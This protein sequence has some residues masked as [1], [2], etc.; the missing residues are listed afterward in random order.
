[1]ASAPHSRCSPYSARARQT[2]ATALAFTLLT[3]G[4][5]TPPPT[6]TASPTP[7]PLPCEAAPST[8]DDPGIEFSATLTS[9]AQRITVEYRV[10]NHN[11][12]PVH[13]PVFMPDVKG[14]PTR[15]SYNTIPRSDG[16]VEIS[17]RSIGFDDCPMLLYQAP[18][19]PLFLPLGPEST[20]A[21]TFIVAMPLRTRHPFPVEPGDI[22]PMPDHPETVVFCL[23]IMRSLE[24]RAITTTMEGETVYAASAVTD[25][26]FE[27]TDPQPL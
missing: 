3:A 18:P 20:F 24:P 25:E 21:E 16:T 13:L 23:G 7:N 17:K 4:C 14:N 5:R 11:T 26:S 27:C 6:P 22:A 8:I 9:T 1:M 12:S 2:T 19:S 10:T 15:A